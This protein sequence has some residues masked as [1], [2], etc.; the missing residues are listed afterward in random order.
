MIIFL[1]PVI[2]LVLI[3][4]FAFYADA[5]HLPAMWEEVERRKYL[6]KYGN[7]G[8]TSSPKAHRVIYDDD[9]D[10]EDDLLSDSGGDFSDSSD[11]TASDGELYG[12]LPFGDG[13]IFMTDDDDFI[14]EFRDDV[15]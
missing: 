11:M 8:R 7:G 5:H 14:D 10:F 2:L 6:K 1:I 13:K 12:G 9:D 3:V 15:L 4:L